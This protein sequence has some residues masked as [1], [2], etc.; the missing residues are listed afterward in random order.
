MLN[1]YLHG[2]V[3]GVAGLHGQHIHAGHHDLVDAGLVEVDDAVDHPAFRG[4]QRAALLADLD[5]LLD[6]VAGDEDLLRAKVQVEKQAD[7]PDAAFHRP[8]EG[9][10]QKGQGPQQ[11]RREHHDLLGI[12]HRSVLGQDLPKDDDKHRHDGD[13]PHQH[14]RTEELE[15]NAGRQGA[16]R[17]VHH[18]VR[19]E[20]DHQRLLHVVNE[21]LERGAQEGAPLLKEQEFSLARRSDGRLRAAEERRQEEQEEEPQPVL[22]HHVKGIALH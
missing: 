11:R 22:Q 21:P 4:L 12:D 15:R 14:P 7:E 10:E 17:D 9:C 16:G 13:H 5:H 6:L 8:D 18:V 19:D 20:A 1:K 2:L 3:Q